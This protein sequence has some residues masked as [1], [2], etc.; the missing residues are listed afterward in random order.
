M[1]TD[2]VIHKMKQN[3]LAKHPGEVKNSKWVLHLSNGYCYY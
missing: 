2:M 1:K 3:I